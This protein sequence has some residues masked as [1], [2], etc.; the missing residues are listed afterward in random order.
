MKEILG[1]A[2]KSKKFKGKLVA[3]AAAFLATKLGL[4]EEQLSDLLMAITG[5]AGSYFLGQGAA[6]FGKEK[7][8]V[9]ANG[10]A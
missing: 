7:A 4:P 10:S 5:I 3:I 6:D 8:K 9:E 1:D 2:L